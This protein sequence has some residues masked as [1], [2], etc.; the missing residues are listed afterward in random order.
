M[1][2]NQT[3]MHDYLLRWLSNDGCK[4]LDRLLLDCLFNLVDIKNKINP[5]EVQN[6]CPRIVD[7][8]EN[9]LFTVCLNQYNS[10]QLQKI[11]II[12]LIRIS[13]LLMW[14]SGGTSRFKLLTVEKTAVS[15]NSNNFHSKHCGI[16]N[17][18]FPL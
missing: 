6:I 13:W 10:S 12:T 15:C 11:Y 2:N 16:N 8:Y 4:R 14:A 18:Y 5:F 17:N 7:I 9:S 1:L 3:L